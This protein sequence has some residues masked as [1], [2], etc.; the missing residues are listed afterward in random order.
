VTADLD[1]DA[2]LKRIGWHGP[3]PPTF[4]MLAGLLRAHMSSIPFEHLD[5]LIGREVK[6][7]LGALQDKLVRARRGGYCFEQTTLF[8]AVL[9]ALGYAPLRHSAR[10]IFVFPRTQAPRS[11]MFLTVNLPEGRFVLDPG[12]G[13][14]APQVPVPLVEHLGAAEP[15]TGHWMVRDGD[16]WILRA[17]VSDKTLDLWTST[18]EEDNPVDFE[19]ANHFTATHPTSVFRSRLLMSLFTRD[20]RVTVLNRDATIRQGETSQTVQLAD[21]AALRKF[22]AEHFGFDE[23]KIETMRVP[24][25]P[26]WE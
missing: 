7:D 14:P 6:L 17:R 24:A 3:T 16:Y 25:V 11:H 21:R 8:A 15:P 26:E 4:A 5:V 1:L 23:P 10:V 20:G 2:Y 19:M 9:E 18:L 12:F 22:V 13:G